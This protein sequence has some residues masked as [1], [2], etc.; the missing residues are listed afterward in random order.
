MF[1]NVKQSF[2]SVAHLIK[3]KYKECASLPQGQTTMK[4][5]TRQV[6][7]RAILTK[8]S[9]KANKREKQPS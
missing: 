7:T 5:N 6:W 1:K 9:H 2:V 4:A 8:L 3:G